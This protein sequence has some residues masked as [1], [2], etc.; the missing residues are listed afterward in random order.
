[1]DPAQLI[2]REKLDGGNYASNEEA[3]GSSGSSEENP[4]TA[5][6]SAS[7]TVTGRGT[8]NMREVKDAAGGGGGIRGPMGT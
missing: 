5:N 8:V 3:S 1:M 6:Y 4:G 2:R 7:R